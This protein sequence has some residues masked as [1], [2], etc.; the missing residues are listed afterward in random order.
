MNLGTFSGVYLPCTQN[1]LGVILFMRMAAI[2]GEAGIW[3]SLLMLL[4][5]CSTT[6]LTTLSLSAIA[7]NGRIRAGGVYYL[8]SRSLGPATGGSIGILYY[9]ALTFAAA[10]YILGSIEALEVG[11][12]VTLGPEAFSNRFLS[13]LLL[14]LIVIINIV[15]VRFIPKAGM[16][17][18]VLV[19]F[20]ILSMLIGLFT[21]GARAD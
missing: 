11:S 18:L 20:T 6:F 3:H 10:M 21:T 8:I 5:C 19:F 16:I 9:I 14:L 4:L 7:T 17:I 12:H 2:V 13:L 1:I 15:G